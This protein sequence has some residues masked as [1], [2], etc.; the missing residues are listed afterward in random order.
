VRDGYNKQEIK[1]KLTEAGFSR[2]KARYSYGRPGSIA[3]R[4]SMK[5][6]L[7]M[8]NVSKAFFILL[9]FWYLIVFPFCLILNFLDSRMA[10]RAGTGLVVMAWK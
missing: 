1:A 8:L 2:V 6:P 4:L 3:W 9:P 10:H 5:W 7:M